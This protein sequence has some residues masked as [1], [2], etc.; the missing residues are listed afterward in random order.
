MLERQFLCAH[1]GTGE[2]VY[3]ILY[4]DLAAAKICHRCRSRI[5]GATHSPV[6]RI[7]E[8]LPTFAVILRRA[9]GSEALD[10][11]YTISWE[12][13]GRVYPKIADTFALIR[14]A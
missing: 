5:D 3:A 6:N 2:A 10:P 14:E 7:S 4:R 1:C 8:T 13:F 11:L 12:V 9:D